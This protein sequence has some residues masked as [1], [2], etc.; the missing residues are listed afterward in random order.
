[1]ETRNSHELFKVTNLFTM[2]RCQFHF[3]LVNEFIE[4]GL[5]EWLQNVEESKEQ[6][7]FNDEMK[8]VNTGAA[9]T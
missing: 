8:L 4:G 3:T 7:L 2:I 1:M 5:F 6:F 9:E